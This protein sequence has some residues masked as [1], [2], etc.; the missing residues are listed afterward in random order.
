MLEDCYQ[1]HSGIAFG[2]LSSIAQPRGDIWGW[3]RIRRELHNKCQAQAEAWPILGLP[4]SSAIRQ[5]T[6][7]TI[8]RKCPGRY[9]KFLHIMKTIV[10][11]TSR[12]DE[13]IPDEYLWPENV[14]LV[15][16]SVGDEITVSRFG[17]RTVVMRHFKY[18]TLT[19]GSKV[20][21]DLV[22]DVICE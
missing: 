22:V 12:Q 4:K 3:P 13:H 15:L 18:E 20:V 9:G 11:V 21:T 17:L 6:T 10:R 16:P 5:S 1:K 19:N 8:D 7:L 14:L 2:G